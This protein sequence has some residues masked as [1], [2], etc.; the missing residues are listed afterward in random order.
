MDLATRDGVLRGVEFDGIASFL[1]VRYGDDTGGPNRFAAPQPVRPW[2]GVR[3]VLEYGPSA[4]QVDIRLTASG[5]LPEALSLLYPR[6]GGPLEGGAASEDC[7]RLNVWAPSRAAPGTL[8]V[9]VWL[10]GGGFTHGSGNE[11]VFTGRSLAARGNVVVSVTHRLGLLGFL[12]LRGLGLPASANAGMLDIVAALDWVAAHIAEVG[13]DS[14]RVTVVG[15]SGGSAKVAALNAMPAARGLFQ[16]SVMMSFPCREVGTPA[17]SAALAAQ[18][19][20]DLEVTDPSRL[21]SLPLETLLAAQATVLGAA[22]GRFGSGRPGVLG[23]FGPSLDPADLP[24]HPFSP[25]PAPGWRG[26]DL[27]IGWNSHDASLLLA[28]SPQYSSELTAED[29]VRLIDED[30]PGQGSTRY[31]RIRAEHPGEPDH[32]IWA[33]AITDRMFADPSRQLAQD[34]AHSCRSVWVYEF[35]RETDVLDRLLGASHSLEL[36]YVFGTTAST[37]FTGTGSGRT[38][39]SQEMMH[40]WSAFAA[41]G[42]PRVPGREWLPVS[43]GTVAPHRFGSDS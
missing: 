32:L 25:T 21:R 29:V 5:R 7:L 4:P 31:H 43:Q 14:S 37:P 35:A 42:A 40:A 23:G 20:A 3:D 2:E 26:T 13:G 22:S 28:E 34:A 38:L 6:T 8:P 36:A 16:R 12:D 11:S 30:E 18:V 15:Q 33:R 39:L 17:G 27:L 24:D 19:L 10:H 41:D 1:G 9:I